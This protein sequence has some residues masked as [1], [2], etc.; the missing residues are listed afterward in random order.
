MDDAGYIGRDSKA[1]EKD[2][3]YKVKSRIEVREIQVTM[4]NGS[5]KSML[6][7]EK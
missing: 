7:D 1:L 2:F 4:K 5:Q 3:D 6:I